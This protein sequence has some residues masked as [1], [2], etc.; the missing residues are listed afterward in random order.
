M[1]K[2]QADDGI[3]GIRKLVGTFGT[4]RGAAFC[5]G[6]VEVDLNTPLGH[7]IHKGPLRGFVHALPCEKP[8]RIKR[9]YEGARLVSGKID[10]GNLGCTA[11]NEHLRPVGRLAICRRAREGQIRIDFDE[12][13][14]LH[15]LVRA[16]LMRHDV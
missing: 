11:A 7:D 5:D 2:E 16:Q 10:L 14:T 9:R 6:L 4:K 15:M 3:E 8:R 12:L 13:D 1:G